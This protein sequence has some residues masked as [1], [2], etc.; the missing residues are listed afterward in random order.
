MRTESVM[1]V[2]PVA[3]VADW[4]PLAARIGY[5]AKGVVYTLIGLFAARAAVGIGGGV[6]S[7]EGV[8]VTILHQPFGRILLAVMALGLACYAFWRFV[9]AIKNPEGSG[10]GDLQEWFQR[11]YALGSGLLHTSLVLGAVGLVVGSG[12]PGGSSTESKTAELMSQPF[13]RWLV[14]GV[15]LV[16]LTIAI[17]QFYRAYKA[18]FRKKMRLH[19]MSAKAR[20]WF[21]RTARWALTARGLVFS[22]IG[23]LLVMAALKVDPSQAAGFKE[24]MRTLESAA[25]GVYL[26]GFTAFGLLFYGLF[27]FAKA[28]YRTIQA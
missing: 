5:A 12:G 18:S 14:G 19:E 24:A 28:K 23:G 17:R 27:Q 25:Y 26:F 2:G 16:V 8:L 7:S 20:T 15:G 3:D 21:E 1:N 22:V 6:E 10:D 9:Q 4:I 13:G 11:A